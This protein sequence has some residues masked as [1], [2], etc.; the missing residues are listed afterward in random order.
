MGWAG[1]EMRRMSRS[2]GDY[3]GDGKTDT[4]VYRGSIGAMVYRSLFGWR[5]YGV[6]WG[7]DTNGS[8]PRQEITMG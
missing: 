3:D 4:A 2:A 6:G 5:N 7:G 1:A 8:C